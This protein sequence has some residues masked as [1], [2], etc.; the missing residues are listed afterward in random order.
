M[1]AVNASRW[2]IGLAL[3]AVVAS[4]CGY[5]RPADP[6]PPSGDTLIPNYETPED[7]LETLAQAI[8]YKASGVTAY[9]GGFADTLS[10]DRGYHGFFDPT[11]LQWANQTGV[12]IPA[13]WNRIREEEFFSG[14]VTLSE[15]PANS[16]FS[17]E[18][19]PDPTQGEDETGTDRQVLHRQYQAFATLTSGDEIPIAKGFATLEFIRM[20]ATR[21]VIVRWQDREDPTAIVAEGEICIGRRRLDGSR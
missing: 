19:D 13:D 20:S 10:D 17:M 9:I 11:T 16:V 12:T 18:W 3:G 4:G 15:V 7:V 21:W 14:F 8:S 2:L 1:A 6:E 5:F